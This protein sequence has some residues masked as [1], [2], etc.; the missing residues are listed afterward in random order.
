MRQGW[1]FPQF[2]VALGDIQMY[3]TAKLPLIASEG[4]E[5]YQHLIFHL[6]LYISLSLH[7]SPSL[8][9]IM[10]IGVAIIG[11]GTYFY[12]ILYAICTG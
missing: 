10:S 9:T 2:E 3:S 7:I 6:Y 11:S 12:N 5:K 1:T 8:Y 4:L